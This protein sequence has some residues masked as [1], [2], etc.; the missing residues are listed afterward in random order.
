MFLKKCWH[1][2]KDQFYKLAH[3]FHG[4]NLSLQNINGSYI[5]LVPKDN[6]PEGVNDYRPISLTNACLKFLSKILVNW[7][8]E[9]ILKCIHK[10]QYGFLK[11][12]SIHD[13]V[14]WTFEYLHQCQA[15]K[16][17]VVVLKLDFAK[18]FDTIEH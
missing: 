11:S 2:V 10:N 16:I 6:S 3:D 13:C 17:P 7:L 12:K 8:Q 4:G 14:A 5:T 18:A 9:V 15:S 1:I